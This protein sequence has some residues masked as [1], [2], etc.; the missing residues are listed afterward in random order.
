[1]RVRRAKSGEMT[2][3]NGRGWFTMN[4]PLS[5]GWQCINTLLWF[6]SAFIR[7]TLPLFGAL[8][9]ASGGSFWPKIFAASNYVSCYE[10]IKFLR[11]LQPGRTFLYLHW[12]FDICLSYL[13]LGCVVFGQK[14]KNA[15][16]SCRHHRCIRFTSSWRP[17]K[18]WPLLSMVFRIFTNQLFQEQRYNFWPVDC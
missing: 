3:P 15:A 13:D 16:N 10:A 7:Q 1:M 9:N 17:W 5:I 4:H 6:L 8:S 12:A 18:S 11:R 2:I 14:Q